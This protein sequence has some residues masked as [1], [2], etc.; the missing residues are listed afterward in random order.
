VRQASGQAILPLFKSRADHAATLDAVVTG[1]KHSLFEADFVG[2]HA[3]ISECIRGRRVMVVGGA[4]SIG[5]ATTGLL[6]AFQPGALH[7]VDQ[8]ENYLAELVRDI[9]SRPEGMTQ[10]DF[11]TFPVDYGGTIMARL[12]GASPPYDMVLNFAALKHVRSERDLFAVLQMLDTN[13]IR[14]WRF[15]EYLARY[16]HGRAYFAVS[17]DKAANPASVM[18]ASKR[19]MEDVVFGVSI[20]HA[21]STTSARFANVAFSNGSLL[22]GFLRRLERR[23]PLA[24]PRDAKR[25]F[26]SCRE[27]A[28][29]CILAATIIPDR[30]VAFPK[31]SPAIELQSLEEIAA[32]VLKFFDLTPEF[33]DEEAPARLE[34][35]NIAARRRWPVLL[36]PLDTSGEKPYEEF[37]GEGEHEVDIGLS[38]VSALRHHPCGALESGLLERLSCFINDT[39]TEIDKAAIVDQLKLALPNFRHSETGRD[40]DQRF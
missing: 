1:R 39:S 30:H 33:L 31:L 9:R 28:E 4:G 25:Y 21:A 22:Q 29:L 3:A 20:E 36:T 40:L 35:E 14:H 10:T 8:S 2:C 6:L 12:L 16:G 38:T 13:I 27:A 17:T 34:V 11:R 32:R 23:Q 18:G 7:I 15:K 26:I 37:V 5:A 19:L 24:V